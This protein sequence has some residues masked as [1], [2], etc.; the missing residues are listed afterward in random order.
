V[1]E[2]IKSRVC[3]PD[4][5]SLVLRVGLAVIFIANG[6][7]KVQRG[8]GTDWEPSLDR[9]QQ[10]I[11]AWTELAA[12]IL[13]GVGLFTRVWAALLFL[14]ALATGYAVSLDQPF[15][16]SWQSAKGFSHLSV[17]TQFNFAFGAMALGVLFLGG[18]LYSVDYCLRNKSW[19]AAAARGSVAAGSPNVPAAP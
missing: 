4:L 3:T 16:G 17:G 15:L 2:R 9:T 14:H 13:I 10:T 7:Y 1:F 12:G 5:A 6:V 18:G 11:V 8:W 19:R